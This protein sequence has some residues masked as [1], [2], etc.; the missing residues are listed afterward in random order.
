MH[1]IEFKTNLQNVETFL[2]TLIKSHSFAEALSTVLKILR[3]LT[4]NICS[5]F[6]FHYSYS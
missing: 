2:I 5:G 6:T 3:T 1:V 4:R